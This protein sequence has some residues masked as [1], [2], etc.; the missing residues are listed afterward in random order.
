MINIV[1]CI[2]ICNLFREFFLEMFKLW[3]IIVF[4]NRL[5]VFGAQNCTKNDGL[6]NCIQCFELVLKF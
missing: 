6:K 5:T 3:K 1:R 2:C 4:F